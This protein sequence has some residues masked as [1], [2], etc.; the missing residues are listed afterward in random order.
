MILPK[1]G[2]FCF[3]N[4][5]KAVQKVQENI[6]DR[7][8]ALVRSDVEKSIELRQRSA[9]RVVVAWGSHIPNIVYCKVNITKLILHYSGKF[10]V[11]KTRLITTAVAKHS[12]ILE[13]GP[14]FGIINSI[15]TPEW[16]PKITNEGNL[17]TEISRDTIMQVM[18]KDRQYG[19]VIKYLQENNKIEK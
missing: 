19:K 17:T 9:L 15:E 3:E 4:I 18:L 8:I 10:E 1:K 13:F 14:I 6:D 5:W 11:F 12:Q 16:F 7:N 2:N